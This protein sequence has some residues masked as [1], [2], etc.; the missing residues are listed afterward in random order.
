[1][2]LDSGVRCWLGLFFLEVTRYPLPFSLRAPCPVLLWVSDCG[3]E[4][5]SNFRPGFP[6]IS[7]VFFSG[8][9]NFVK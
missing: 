6:G 4:F 5:S 9:F 7:V 3:A 2:A 8:F 1:V